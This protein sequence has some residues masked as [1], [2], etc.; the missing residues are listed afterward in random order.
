MATCHALGSAKPMYSLSASRP[1][2]CAFGCRL[3]VDSSCSLSLT[4]AG[5]RSAAFIR[6]MTG[7]GQVSGWSGRSTREALTDRSWQPPTFI[8]QI[9][10]SAPSLKRV[11]L[12]QRQPIAMREDRPVEKRLEAQSVEARASWPRRPTV[13]L[14][15]G[16]ESPGTSWARSGHR[17]GTKQNA[18]R[19]GWRSLRLWAAYF[20]RI[21]WLRGQDLN[22]RPLGYEPNELPDCSTSRLSRKV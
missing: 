5:R 8:R 6:S 21:L 2:V 3:R 16:A 1:R 17:M 20:R 19:L 4:A 9:R 13:M 11:S 22:L 12:R 18:N 7:E 15:H 14:V 10:T